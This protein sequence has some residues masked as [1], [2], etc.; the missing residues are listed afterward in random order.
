[1]K[2][3]A[4]PLKTIFEIFARQSVRIF[5]SAS[6]ELVL[7][8]SL[9]VLDDQSIDNMKTFVKQQQ[10]DKGGFADRAGKCDLYYSL[11]GCFLA[12]ALEMEEVLLSLKEY[13]KNV[14]GNQ[15]VNGVHL[16]VAAILYIK[17]FDITT[18]PIDF[19][20]KVYQD[21]LLQ[22]KKQEIYTGFMSM[23]TFYYLEDY[24]GLYRV[25][26][27][28]KGISNRTSMPCSVASAQLILQKC[29]G[30]PILSMEKLLHSFYRN[31]GSFNA[32]TG[33]PTGDLLSTGV[34][35]YAFRLANSDIRII[36]PD[37]LRYVDALF[38]GGGFCA[39][40]YDV[41]PD[42][43]YTFYGLLAVGSLPV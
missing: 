27:H 41:Q 17:L 34:A 19:K 7:K 30:K 16:H 23:L 36:A 31:D 2:F 28:L 3:L 33:A 32:I 37:C 13:V 39:T 20:E 43:E 4:K 12:E 29:F 9:Q 42:V 6:I 25:G 11:F 15:T 24:Y 14:I 35:L 5:Q 26:K 40:V 8:K 18:F 1:M 22:N 21:L 10:T 38:T